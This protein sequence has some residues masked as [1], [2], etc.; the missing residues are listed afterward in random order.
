MSACCQ[1]ALDSSATLEMN[2][3]FGSSVGVTF[4]AVSP[5]P[6]ASYVCLKVSLSGRDSE[7]AL[8]PRELQRI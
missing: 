3:A 8:V 4:C 1:S 7:M 2:L 6:M 5:W